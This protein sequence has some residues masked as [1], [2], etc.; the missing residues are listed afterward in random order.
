M[1]HNIL[2]FSVVG[3][4]ALGAGCA[5]PQDSPPLYPKD[6]G[7]QV[8][9]TVSQFDTIAE[10]PDGHVGQEI[11]LAGRVDTLEETPEG[12]QVLAK[13]LPYPE[14]KALDQ[15]PRDPKVDPRRHF[16]IRF[17]GK[18]D[19][20]FVT[21]HGNKFILEG[22]VA[23]TKGTL[24]N[25]FGLRKDLLYVNATCV[26]VWETGIDVIS[27]DPDSEFPD[28]RNKTFCADQ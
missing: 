28:V 5:T 12:Y 2:V 19:R 25:M 21:T 24:I 27:Q 4:I 26:H 3:L 7:A 15:G 17:K 20:T 10:N 11:K 22:T 1:K 14:K 18:R 6:S 16:L 9:A 8:V 13:W 23:G